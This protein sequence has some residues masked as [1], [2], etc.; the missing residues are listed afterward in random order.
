METLGVNEIS[1]RTIEKDIYDMRYNSALGFN[2]PIKYNTKLNGYYYEDENYSIDNIPLTNEDMEVIYFANGILQQYSG[3]GILKSFQGA[4][5]KISEA[6][7]INKTAQNG[8]FEFIHFDVPAY[9]KG[10]EYL[11]DVFY[12]IQN[13][14]ELKFE[15]QKFTNNEVKTYTFQPYLLKEF[16]SLWYAIGIVS[17]Y[18]SV[19]TFALD[20][21][22]NLEVTNNV[23]VRDPS[24]N[25]DIYVNNVYG[26]SQAEGEVQ[27]ILLETDVLTGH[28]LKVMPFHPSQEISFLND[29][30]EVQLRLVLNQELA[31][32]ILSF[33]KGIKI[34]A[35]L[36]LKE[37]MKLKAKE[38]LNLYPD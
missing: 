24:F 28:Y 15:Y 10:G 38:V 3:L 27:E 7:A 16:N 11:K 20:R 18:Q 5:D 36:E 2:A 33:G 1:V 4:V 8:S 29:R 35:P 13:Q 21:F 34:K 19:R 12:G 17:E 32:K 37:L 6:L 26:V 14:R 31:M 25:M 23:F 30:C 9:V 22:K